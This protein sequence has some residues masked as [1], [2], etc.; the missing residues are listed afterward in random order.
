MLG[1]KGVSPVFFLQ[2]ALQTSDRTG[3]TEKGVWDNGDKK[4]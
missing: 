2:Q 1:R 4:G 3:E